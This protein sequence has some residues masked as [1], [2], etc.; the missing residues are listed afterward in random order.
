M[1]NRFLIF[2]ALLVS[3]SAF[4][5]TDKSSQSF[6]YT[7]PAHENLGLQQSLWY[8]SFFD[9]DKLYAAQASIFYQ[10][11]WRTD[12]IK[13]LFLP[14]NRTLVKINRT[15]TDRDVLPEWLGLPTD[16]SGYLTVNPEQEQ[17][18]GCIELRRNLPPL[19]G[20]KFFQDWWIHVSLPITHV[21][22]NL[23][24]AQSSVENAGAT[25]LNVYDILTAFKNPDWNY[26]KIDGQRS[27]TCPAEV[28]FTLGATMLSSSRAHAVTYS[29]L[30]IPTHKKLS[31]VY[32]FDSQV[33]FNRHVGILW[34]AHL[35]APFTRENDDYTATFNIN[36]ENHFLIRNHQFR[37]FDL[38][39]KEWSRFLNLRLKD[40]T[41][42]TLTPGVNVLTQEVRVSP[43]AVVDF[44]ASVRCEYKGIEGELGCGVWGYGGD[45]IKLKNPWIEEYGIAGTTTNTSASESTIKTRASDDATFT[46]IKESDL[47]LDSAKMLPAVTYKVYGSLGGKHRGSKIDAHFGIGAFGEFPRNPTKVLS[48]WGVLV[49]GGGAF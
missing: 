41:T 38:K 10:K 36:L 20:F 1:K 11:S 45:S 25:T 49:K 5:K 42:N 7:R 8:S 31:G 19:F 35:Q 43:H 3:Q 29:A 9:K 22:N 46:T 32:M 14:T 48:T 39:N 21:K 16:F 2:L 24:L 12:K 34:G 30:S 27:Q 47:N 33:G 15:A 13:K 44:A 40:Q 28:R 6:L 37:T 18:G 23:N 26:A 17:I 4:S